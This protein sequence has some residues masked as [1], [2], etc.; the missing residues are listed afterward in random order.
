MKI[1]IKPNIITKEKII[2]RIK[3]INIQILNNIQ[4]LQQFH[5]K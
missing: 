2:M 4:C 1:Y 5:E 3:E